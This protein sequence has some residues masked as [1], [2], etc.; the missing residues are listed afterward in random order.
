MKLQLHALGTQGT[1]RTKQ[2]I[3]GVSETDLVLEIG[4]EPAVR[5][6]VRVKQTARKSTGGKAPRKVEYNIVSPI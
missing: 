4:I 3:L 5:S 6:M 2:S 1:K